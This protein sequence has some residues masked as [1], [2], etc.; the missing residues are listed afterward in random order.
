[1]E[2]FL[3]IAIGITVISFISI[4]LTEPNPSSSEELIPEPA[5]AELISEEEA[6]AREI[7]TQKE[8]LLSDTE[9]QEV[10]E[11]QLLATIA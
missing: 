7:S 4:V 2:L 9:E 1:M 3:L 5:Q 11:E 8:G 6:K 10:A